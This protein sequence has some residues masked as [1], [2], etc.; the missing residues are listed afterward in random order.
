MQT[1]DAIIPAYNEGPRV[2]SVVSACRQSELVSSVIVVD[3]GSRDDTAARALEAGASVLRLERNGGKAAAMHAGAVRS[4][5]T[6]LLFLDADLVGIEPR[7]VDAL[8]RPWLSGARMVVGLIHEPQ[9]KLWSVFSGQRVLSRASWLWAVRI[10]PG[11][12]RSGYGVEVH[13]AMLA[14][15][16]GW[17]VV[18]VPL[19]GIEF[20]HQGQK[21]G[22]KR[23]W[24]SLRMWGRVLR[25]AA[26]QGDVAA[27]RYVFG[28]MLSN[29]GYRFRHRIQHP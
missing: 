6:G 28:P 13:L 25:E 7:H 2:A 10:R 9:R 1:V 15:M 5:A 11:M 21:W 18:E 26:S 20:V 27:L 29:H 17:T 12:I 19:E 8:I 16:Y 24:R 23:G 3:D 22:G 14:N 4:D